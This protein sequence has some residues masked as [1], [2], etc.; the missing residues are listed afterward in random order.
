M[1]LSKPL[2]G[3]AILVLSSA[4][5]AA[6]T[7]EQEVEA[8]VWRQWHSNPGSCIEALQLVGRNDNAAALDRLKRGQGEK[9][10]RIYDDAF[11]N[12][13]SRLWR[14]LTT[15]S[16]KADHADIDKAKERI[17]RQTSSNPQSICNASA[18]IDNGATSGAFAKRAAAGIKEIFIRYQI[19]HDPDSLLPVMEAA[20]FIELNY[21]GIRSADVNVL[22]ESEKQIA[23][24]SPAAP[25]VYRAIGMADRILTLIGADTDDPNGYGYDFATQL[26]AAA[27]AELLYPQR[28]SPGTMDLYRSF[29]KQDLPGFYAFI[30]AKANA[31]QCHQ[32]AP[33]AH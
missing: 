10:Q 32:D 5:A 14:I 3:F 8:L 18:F 24:G 20:D 7:L 16:P 21:R 27:L 29:L 17:N 28:F 11:L 9:N 15:S 22:L 23:A 12:L 26:T 33:D 2:A 1:R 31:I 19:S 30:Y 4:P 13:G 6:Q 25:D